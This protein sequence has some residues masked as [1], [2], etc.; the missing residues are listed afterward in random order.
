VLD[1]VTSMA[2]IEDVLP[3]S[4]NGNGHVLI[5]SRI[6]SWRSVHRLGLDP[7]PIESAA[8]ILTADGAGNDHG[9][10]VDLAEE[11]GRL[12]LALG[13]AAAYTA[14]TGISTTDYLALYRDE[15]TRLLE[16]GVASAYVG[17]VAAAISLSE[18][19][20][21]C[22]EPIAAQVLQV[23]ALWSGDLLPLR[24]IV[25]HLPGSGSTAAGLGPVDVLRVLAAL[26]E[27]GLLTVDSADDVHMHRLTRVVVQERIADRAARLRDSVAILAACTRR[28]PRS[29]PLGTRAPG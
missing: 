28:L 22:K 7:L 19:R 20:L 16:C 17:S 21:A 25:E 1:N 27:S 13:Q 24:A 15:R 29:P 23:C 14:Q 6:P 8:R 12:P 10:A 4:S 3:R 26:R 5:T 9:A 2:V 11:L 18:T